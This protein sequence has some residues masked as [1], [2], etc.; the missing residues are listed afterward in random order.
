MHYEI[1]VSLGEQSNPTR[2]GKTKLLLTSSL[3]F[4][5]QAWGGENS[6]SPGEKVT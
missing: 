2:K 1:L 5:S 3:S 6:L 4:P